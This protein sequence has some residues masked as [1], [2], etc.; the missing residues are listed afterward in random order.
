M[1]SPSMTSRLLSS[2]LGI[3]SPLKLFS[4]STRPRFGP[5]CEHA[6][7]ANT[8]STTAALEV[9]PPPSILKAEC[10]PLEPYITEEVDHYFITNWPF[11]N[12]DAKEKFRAA[13]FSRVTCC[14]FP[15]ALED[16]IIFAC[17]LLTLLF[18]IDGSSKPSASSSEC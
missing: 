12:D 6:A 8:V 2:L 3:S 11:P 1:S 13:G 15:E 7:S 18:L 10:H 16:R 4:T 9:I 14:Y 17:K 5:C